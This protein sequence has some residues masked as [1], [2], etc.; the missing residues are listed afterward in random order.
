MTTFP[1]KRQRPNALALLWY[2]VP[3]A[4]GCSPQEEPAASPPH[5]PSDVV[6]EWNEHLLDLAEAEDGFLTLKGVRTASIMH[7]AIHNALNSIEPTYAVYGG[8]LES[9]DLTSFGSTTSGAHPVAT[10]AQAA[11]D[12]VVNQYPDSRPL[13]EGLLHRWLEQVPNS[14]AKATGI[15]LGARSAAAAMEVRNGDAWDSEPEYRWHPMGPG[16]YAEFQE[17]SGTPEG[18]VFGAG[19]AQARPFLLSTPDQ[20]RST[21]PPQIT[22]DTYAQAFEEVRRV[23]ARS[24]EVR[25]PDQAHLAMWWKDFVERSHNRLAR[26]L[27]TLDDPGLWATA[28]LFALLNMSI[29]DGY[30]ASFD[31][32]FHY[33]H[34]RP[35]TAIRWA[36]NDG[37]PTTD[38]DPSWDNLHG[39][40]YAFPSYPSAHG[41]VCAAAMSI[42]TDVF[43][44]EY[45][46]TM[47]TDAVD[48]AGPF[49]G[50]VEMDPPTRSF[51]S[52]DEAARECSL[53]RIYLGIHFRYDSDAGTELGRQIGSLAVENFMAPLGRTSR[54]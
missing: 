51:T 48:R 52:F 10:A 53:S 16:V 39:H 44:A 1:R 7:V 14:A 54:R 17:H 19:W 4:L 36:S 8:D 32:K 33:N 5:V 20:F 11:H 31:S 3:T 41:T 37:N 27:A 47:R 35:Y 15:S 46:F 34:W 43:G 49:S 2:V 40:T 45:P 9:R 22:S 18:F 24:S 13:T 6:V 42:L 25:T 50:K 38:A 26:S 28:R 30:V 23:G 21:P 12:V 29:F